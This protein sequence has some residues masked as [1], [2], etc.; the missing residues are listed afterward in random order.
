MLFSDRLYRL[1][2]G[3]AGSKKNE[4]GANHSAPPSFKAH[5]IERVS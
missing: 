1:A 2:R 4:G 5:A 3:E